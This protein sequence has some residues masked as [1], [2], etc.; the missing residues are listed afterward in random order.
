M[1]EIN[2]NKGLYRYEE[3]D[4]TKE[5]YIFNKEISKLL[6]LE[7]LELFK[8]IDIDIILIYGTLL[9]AIREKDL[10]EHDDDVD[11]I[12]PEHKKD[13][14]I[15]ALHEFRTNGYEL[16]RN[17]GNLF[18]LEKDG[19]YIDIYIFIAMNNVLGD[20]Y[21]L[22]NNLRISHEILN[23]TIDYEL[24]GK[25]FKIPENW[26]QYLIEEYGSDW[27]TPKINYRNDGYN[28]RYYMLRKYVPNKIYN[29]IT[30]K[31]HLKAYLKNLFYSLIYKK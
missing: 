3:K 1:K 8:A 29:Y 28:K 27:R 2:T 7:I 19:Q 24:F 31:P 14:F 12:I 11:L 18:S 10:I 20:K 15:N 9:G 21:W 5:K 4:I 23:K 25:T 13:I 26:E 6:L 17:E 30:S 16:I 22:C